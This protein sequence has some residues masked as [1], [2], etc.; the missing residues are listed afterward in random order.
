MKLGLSLD[1]LHRTGDDWPGGMVAAHRVEGDP[2]GLLL[3][4]VDDLAVLVVAAGGAD[5][6]RQ[7]GLLAARAILDLN[8]LEVLVAA[9][10]ALP[11]VGGSSLRNGHDFLPCWEVARK[12]RAGL[13]RHPSP[14]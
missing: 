1:G 7:D 5:A 13:A 12:N 3:L 8:G 9:P 14:S 6:V 2:H 10:L 4:H 11:G